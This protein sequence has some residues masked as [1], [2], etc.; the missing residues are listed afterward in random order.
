MIL[1]REA[2]R[3]WADTEIAGLRSCV[4]WSNHAGD[5]GYF[6][7]FRAGTRFPRHG[8][9]GWEQLYVVSGAIRFDDVEL[10]PGDL[11]QVQAS[12]EHE[13]IALEDTVVFVAHRG[14]IQ[15]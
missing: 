10:H 14:G 13:A 2:T 6:A 5:G 7:Q 1:N 8:H 12:D 4:A 11:L 9:E 15:F 3:V